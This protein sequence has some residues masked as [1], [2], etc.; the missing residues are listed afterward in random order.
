MRAED[1]RDGS[2]TAG[3]RGHQMVNRKHTRKMRG[4][5]RAAVASG[6]EACR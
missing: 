5:S 3:L 2:G 4:G 6:P 1:Q